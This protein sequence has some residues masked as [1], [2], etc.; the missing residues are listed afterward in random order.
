MGRRW[1][2]KQNLG[3]TSYI[4]SGLGYCLV[5]IQ[6]YLVCIEDDI[7]MEHRTIT[8]YLHFT[9]NRIISKKIA[10]YIKFGR[11]ETINLLDISK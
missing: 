7:F 1:Y 4:A 11:I 10:D 9:G 5:R 2:R 3:Q 8:N 6:V